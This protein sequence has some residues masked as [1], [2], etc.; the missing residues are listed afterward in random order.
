MFRKLG[1]ACFLLLAEICLLGSGRLISAIIPGFSLSDMAKNAD[2]IAIGKIHINAARSTEMT[3][4]GRP[5]RGTEYFADVAADSVLKPQASGAANAIRVHWFVP[6]PGPNDLMYSGVRDG[7]YLLFFLKLRPGEQAYEFQSPFYPGLSVIPG[8]PLTSGDL[9]GQI[10]DQ[11]CAFL[12]SAVEGTQEKLRIITEFH[13]VNNPQ[14]TST[15][16]HLLAG[17]EPR[18]EMAA[19]AALLW[20]K[21]PESVSKAGDEILHGSSGATVIERQNL[22]LALSENFDSSQSLLVLTAA[23]MASD[24]GIRATSAYGLR[25]TRSANSVGPLLSAV[26][27]IDSEV[28]WNAMHSL[29]ELVNHL[30]W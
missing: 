3:I 10:I 25:F 18:L 16:R 13:G 23:L 4:Q 30:D 26:D 27:D 6:V 9:E 17:S 14:F 19:L 5:Y 1:Y 11:V 15:L 2:V 22:I 29:G 24:P 21:D 8:I 20:R 28:Q 7:A 12:E